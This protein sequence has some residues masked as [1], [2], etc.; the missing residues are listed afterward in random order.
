MICSLR[1]LNAEETKTV[2]AAV[3]QGF[4]KDPTMTALETGVS[5][6]AMI[7]TDEAV[8]IH[9]AESAGDR[10]RCLTRVFPI[11]DQMKTYNRKFF[12]DDLITAFTIAFVL[13]PQSIA[14]E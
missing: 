9:K 1:V 11:I 13:L 4:L 12:V 8:K 5:K 14:C 2:T 3:F 7:P 6:A 10:K